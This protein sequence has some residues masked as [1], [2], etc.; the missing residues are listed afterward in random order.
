MFTDGDPGATHGIANGLGLHL[1]KDVVVWEC[2]VLGHFATA[3]EGEHEIQLLLIVQDL[4]LRIF[5]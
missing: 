4:A 1:I 5:V 2:Q 3:V